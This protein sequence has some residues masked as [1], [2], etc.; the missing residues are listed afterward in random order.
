MAR[1]TLLGPIG[2]VLLLPLAA[3]F[4]APRSAFLHRP[5]AEARAGEPLVV[6]GDVT[7][8]VAF[9]QVVLKVRGPN[10]DYEELRLELQYGDLYRVTLPASRMTP[11]GIEYCVE[12]VLPSGERLALLSTCARPVR[13]KIG[14]GAWA[15]EEKE[16]AKEPN[17]KKGKK[18]RGEPKVEKPPEEPEPETAELEEP[19]PGKK[20]AKLEAKQESPPEEPEPTKPPAKA[21]KAEAKKEPPAGPKPAPPSPPSRPRTELEEE[22]ALYGAEDLSGQVQHLETRSL[23]STLAPIVLTAE[24]LK[25]LG[26]RT[27]AEALDLVPSLS[28]SRDVQGFHRVAVR[29]LRND[30]E[31]LVLLDGV[32]LNNAYDGKALLTLPVETLSRIEV[33]RGPATVDFGPGDF[34]GVVNLVTDRDDGVR[35]L[36][37]GG[38]WDAFDAHLSAARRSGAVQFFG[39]GDLVSQYGFKRPVPRDAFDTPTVTRP[40]FTRDKRF[41]VNAGAGVAYTSDAAGTLELSGRYLLEDRSALIGAFDT[42]GNSSRL[43]WSTF[44]GA[45]SWRKQLSDT[46]TVSAQAFIDQQ[47][48][49]RLWQLTPAG[50]QVRANDPATLFPDGMLEEIQ[51]G[52]RTLG[53]DA[54]VELTLPRENWLEAGLRVEEQSLT[55]YA[56]LTNYQVGANTYTPTLARAGGVVYPTEDGSGGRGKAADRFTLGLFAQDIWRPSSV[57][58]V[59]AGVRLDLFQLPVPDATGKLT[60]SIVTAGL[61]PRIGVVLAPFDALALRLHYGRSVRPPTVQELAERPPNSDIDQGHLIGNPSLVPTTIDSV[62]GGFEYLQGVGDAR[63]RL[64]ATTFYERLANPIASVDTTGNQ[65]PWANRPLGVQA[66]GLDGEA[67]LELSRRA[68]AWVNAAW[69]R[70]EDLGTPAQSRLLTDVPQVRFNA[71]LTIPIGPYLNFDV[72]SRFASERRN[73]SRSVLE[74]IRRY[75]LPAYTVVTAQLRTEP[76]FDRVELGVLGQNVF[77]VE[78]SDDAVR[79]DRITGGVPR[80][81]VLVFGTVRVKL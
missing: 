54:R 34:L 59:Q 7:G 70:A 55:S 49:D 44:L 37:S 74:L 1:A 39:S 77:N 25:Q 23:K 3:S 56:W 21:T 4:G 36:A 27:V 63:L 33:F 61:G 31:L 40:K 65:V 42:V 58:S 43:Q 47:S 11:P 29:G 48:T 60:G 12:G 69:V 62:Q 71:G 10:E 78:Y 68:N 13:V 22:L 46:A 52:A 73:D 17:G 30:P 72:V 35:L 24:Q 38:S 79:P 53:L 6:E 9:S 64:T 50:Y 14:T 32:R 26:V 2:L 41:V 75:T 18:G 16:P 67:R 57:L 45:L 80:E 20:G 5:P 15:G 28:V 19:K 8:N 51:V 66:L 81:S 76:L